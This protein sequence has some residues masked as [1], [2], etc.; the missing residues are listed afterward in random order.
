MKKDDFYIVFDRDFNLWLNQF[1]TDEYHHVFPK[2]WGKSLTQI[3]AYDG[4]SSKWIRSKREMSALSRHMSKKPLDTYYFQKTGQ[5]KYRKL[6]EELRRLISSPVSK[7]TNPTNH[8]K[9]IRDLFGKDYFY[10]A[11]C[12]FLPGAWKED[13]LRFH[14]KEKNKAERVVRLTMETRENI[15]GLLKELGD[16]MRKWLG[17][18]LVKNGYPKEWVKL[19]T[20]DETDRFVKTGKLPPYEKLESRS[21]GYVYYK[22]RVY[23][24]KDFKEFLKTKGIRLQEKKL[25]RGTRILYGQV[26]FSAKT[27]KG[28]VRVVKNSEESKLVKQGEILISPMTAP[29]Y[30]PAM[31]KAKGIVTD[32]GGITCHAAIVS[33]EL[34]IPCVIGTKIATQVFKDG[35]LVE[36]DANKGI[37]RKIDLY[38]S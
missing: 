18:K 32:E 12:V 19:L 21:S 35:D 8:L 37:V 7:V 24:T 29:D 16:Y 5:S 25:S 6:A 28:R 30:L 4:R 9:Q 33:R 10:N 23:D 26:A 13:F 3:V 31:K 2:I 11:L 15:E 36:V 20:I 38:N 14:K 34:G 27:V 1:A 22:D 17:P